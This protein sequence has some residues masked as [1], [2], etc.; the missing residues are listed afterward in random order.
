[1]LGRKLSVKGKDLLAC[2]F[3]PPDLVALDESEA[4][5][6]SERSPSWLLSCRLQAAGS[7]CPSLP[8]PHGVQPSA[9]EGLGYRAGGR[10][11]LGAAAPSGPRR[12]AGRS[13]DAVPP[14][15]AP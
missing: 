3:L 10:F 7:L 14:P 1:M 12:A 9:S 2:P 4:S 6:G 15:A 8:G 13:G 5:G 11:S